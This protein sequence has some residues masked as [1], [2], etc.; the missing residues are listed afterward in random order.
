MDESTRRNGLTYLQ[1]SIHP[2]AS[3]VVG[4]SARFPILLHRRRF[5]SNRY[6]LHIG[7]CGHLESDI[8]TH[9]F[10]VCLVIIALL[11]TIER[12]A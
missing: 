8:L 12:D 11:F 1:I 6:R 10:S 7:T 2:T 9:T 5:A 4:T 3:I